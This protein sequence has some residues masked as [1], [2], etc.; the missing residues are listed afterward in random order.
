M[1]HTFNFS[2]IA[3]I[4]LN[5]SVFL[6]WRIPALQKTMSKWFTA[7]PLSGTVM[8]IRFSKS[9]PDLVIVPAISIVFV[10]PKL[11]KV[12]KVQ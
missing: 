8:L 1:T 12:H 10:W 3:I 7:T 2:N 9:K 11:V 4:L 5:V 6:L